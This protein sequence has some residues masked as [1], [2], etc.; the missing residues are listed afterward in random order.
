MWIFLCWQAAAGKRGALDICAL[1]P[2]ALHNSSCFAWSCAAPWELWQDRSQNVLYIHSKLELLRANH[3]HS[4]GYSEMFLS[5]RRQLKCG[6]IFSHTLFFIKTQM[7]LSFLLSDWVRNIPCFFQ[8]NSHAA[9]FK[10]FLI[11]SGNELYWGTTWT[12]LKLQFPW[13]A[14][15]PIL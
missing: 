2:P 9:R 7:S 10:L 3:G 13:V 5:C 4:G 12:P 1:T 8:A 11:F 14:S 15:S 6:F